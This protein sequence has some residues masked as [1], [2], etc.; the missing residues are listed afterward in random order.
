[1]AQEK[2]V[3]YYRVSTEKQRNSKNKKIKFQK[4]YNSGLGL[5]SQRIACSEYVKSKKGMLL[6]EF[7]EIQSAAQKDIIKFGKAVNLNSLLR[8]RPVLLAALNYSRENNAI[9]VVKEASRLTRFKLLGE[10]L[11]ATGVRFVCTDSPNDDNFI[12]G[13]KISLHQEEAENIS[14]KTSAALQ[15]KLKREGAWQ[16]PNPDYISGKVASYVINSKLNEGL[17]LTQI[18]KHLNKN[19]FHTARGKNFSPIQ[20][21]RLIK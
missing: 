3:C 16:T 2:F 10:Y 20:V 12:I 6:K 1:M 18:A 7:E 21:K 8:K 5:A 17:N 19:K 13:I 9:L 15:A 4:D 11:M 14:R